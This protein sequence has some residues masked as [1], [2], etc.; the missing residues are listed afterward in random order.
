MGI[1][2]VV[3]RVAIA[4]IGLLRLPVMELASRRL[5]YKLRPLNRAPLVPVA[6]SCRR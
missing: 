1:V 3:V 2:P 5:R 6:R 4:A